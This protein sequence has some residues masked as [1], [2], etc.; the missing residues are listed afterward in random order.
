MNDI[1]K[2]LHMLA[3]S[4]IVSD[5]KSKHAK[6]LRAIFARPTLASILFS[7]I[8]LLLISIGAVLHEREGSRVKFVLGV[9]EW[10]AHRPHPGKE[11]KKYQVEDVRE[12]LTLAEITP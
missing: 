4:A 12:F 7:D 10:H 9:D 8:E 2:R 3:L 6:T 5:M 11:A 1:E